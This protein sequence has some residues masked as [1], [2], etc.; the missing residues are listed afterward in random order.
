MGLHPP[1]P[2]VAKA[3]SANAVEDVVAA[4]IS[5]SL[6]GAA[7][8]AGGSGIGANPIGLLSWLIN[9][10]DDEAKAAD[11]IWPRNRLDPDQLHCPKLLFVGTW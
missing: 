3:G 9:R 5:V 7:G 10:T 8:I 2:R 4:S 11:V 1:N 6:I